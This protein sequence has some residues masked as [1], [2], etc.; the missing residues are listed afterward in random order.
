MGEQRGEMV[1]CTH[2]VQMSDTGSL[3][4]LAVTALWDK[5][6]MANLWEGERGDLRLSGGFVLWVSSSTFSCFFSSGFRAWWRSP[7]LASTAAKYM[8]SKAGEVL[9]LAAVC[10]VLTSSSS[11]KLTCFSPSV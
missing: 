4:L 7:V 3:D 1:V 9:S 11:L 8:K 5:A 10:D 6:A 2:A